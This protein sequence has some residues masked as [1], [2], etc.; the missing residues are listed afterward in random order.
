MHLNGTWLRKHYRS[1]SGAI[2]FITCDFINGYGS[3]LTQLDLGFRG[4]NV[5]PLMQKGSDN[6]YFFSFYFSVKT[7]QGCSTFFIFKNFFV[8]LLPYFLSTSDV[9]PKVHD[10]GKVKV[11][12]LKGFSELKLDQNLLDNDMHLNGTWLRKHYRSYSGAILFI[13]C[14]FINGYGSELTQLDLGFRGANVK[15]L[16]QKGSDNKYFF[17]FYFSVK[18][19][20]G[21][22]TFFIFKN[23]FVLLLPYFLSTS[24]VS[25]KVHDDG[26]VKVWH[27]K[28]FSELK[29]DQNL[30]DND[31]HLNGTWLRKHYRSYSGAILFITCDFIN[32]Y[33]SELTQLDLG[34]RGANVKPLMQKGSD[35]KYFFSFYFSVKT[36]Q[37]CSTQDTSTT[38]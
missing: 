8:L 36:Y 22:S 20:Q 28:G 33:G 14:D 29:L 17:S 4:A 6:K 3:E 23:F 32:G 31:M 1:Y 9:S 24:D 11:W 26:K 30:L 34:F 7:Y 18:T 13:T 12:H 5:K 21:C 27:L 37:G 19:Y 38:W 35:N 25:P 2:L 10:D 16:M 15:P